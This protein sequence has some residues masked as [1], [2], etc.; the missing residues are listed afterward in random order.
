MKFVRKASS[1]DEEI[2]TSIL[3]LNRLYLHLFI[4]TFYNEMLLLTV[5]DFHVYIHTDT[6]AFQQPLVYILHES[7]K[8]AK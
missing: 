7:F 2:K 1:T 3:V 5:V 8:I 6:V 4:L